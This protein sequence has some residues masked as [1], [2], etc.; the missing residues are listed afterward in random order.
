[1]GGRLS[2]PAALDSLSVDIL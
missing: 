2:V 1:M